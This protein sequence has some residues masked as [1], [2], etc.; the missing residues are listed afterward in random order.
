MEGR[1]PFGEFEKQTAKEI[2]KW[3]A[4]Q[5]FGNAMQVLQFFSIIAI[6]VYIITWVLPGERLA[7]REMYQDSERTHEKQLQMMLE[8]HRDQREYDSERHEREI[9]TISETVDKL[10]NELRPRLGASK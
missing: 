2:V 5:P 1:T 8:A 3:F 6:S 9:E 10:L 7:I 4:G